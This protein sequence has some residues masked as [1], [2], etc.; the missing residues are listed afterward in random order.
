M[1]TLKLVL[2]IFCIIVSVICFF[3]S[4]AF[5]ALT[6]LYEIIEYNYIS[7]YAGLA[8]IVC[9]MLMLAG[10][11]VAIAGREKRDATIAAGVV[12]VI[13][14]ICAYAGNQQWHDFGDLYVYGLF[15]G[16]VS[17][18]CFISLAIQKDL[19]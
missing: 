3:E 12:L 11:I 17:L 5:G 8:G 10:G 19:Y 18:L 13:S 1:K 6:A 16:I 4:V 2:G 7:S 14:A 9:S 15:S